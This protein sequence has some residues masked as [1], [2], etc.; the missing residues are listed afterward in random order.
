MEAISAI[1]AKVAEAAR[2]DEGLDMAPFGEPIA[3]FTDRYF[4]G[5]AF[6][7]R[8]DGQPFQAAVVVA[9]ED[10]IAGLARDAEIP[11]QHRH[12]LSI[13]HPL[14]ELQP[15]IHLATLPNTFALLAK[16]QKCNPCLRNDLSPISRE[17]Q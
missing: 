10:L 11:A 2:R 7:E 4:D 1:K 9:L 14:D 13:Q 3:F 12:L 16:G 17:G 6:T 8:F 5:A 15:L